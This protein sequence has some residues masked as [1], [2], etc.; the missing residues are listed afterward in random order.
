MSDESEVELDTQ[1][2]LV[3]FL[4]EKY[5]SLLKMSLV[6]EVKL[7]KWEICTFIGS[8]IDCET[9]ENWWRRDS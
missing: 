6:P 7:E 5:T 3:D 4:I 9:G 1:S 2:I 8:G